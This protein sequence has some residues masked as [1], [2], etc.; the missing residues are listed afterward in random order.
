MAIGAVHLAMSFVQLKSRD[1]VR[2]IL[3]VPSGMTRATLVVQPSDFLARRVAGTTIEFLMESIERPTGN[4][5]RE[6]R[7][8]FRVVALGTLVSFVAITADRVDFYL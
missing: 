5:V 6:C 8:L 3:L 1:I 4:G 2:E 7:F